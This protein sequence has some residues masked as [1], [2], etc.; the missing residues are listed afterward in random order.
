MPTLV[1]VR[2]SNHNSFR[3]ILTTRTAN[4]DYNKLQLTRPLIL[5]MLR[6]ARASKR[7]WLARVL[8]RSVPSFT[9]AG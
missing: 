1:R 3:R 6:S 8:K 2:L 4:L 7:A 9:Y 5:V